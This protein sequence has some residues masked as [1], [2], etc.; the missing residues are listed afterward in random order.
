MSSSKGRARSMISEPG[1]N[2]VVWF[3]GAFVPWRDAKM[4]V[5]AHHYGFGVFEGVRAYG[6]EEGV[7]IFRL[8]DHTARLLRSAHILK[9]RIPEPFDSNLLND[10]QLELLRRNGF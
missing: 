8:H 7:S 4:H 2:H 5:S 9:L 1:P 10:V 6:Y 3:D